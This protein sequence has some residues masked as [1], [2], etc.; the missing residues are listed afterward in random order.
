MRRY[1]TLVFMLFLV[2]PA[3]ISFSGCTRNPAGNYCNGLGYGLKDTDVYRI[4]LEPKTTGLSLAFGQEQQISAPQAF[5]CKGSNANAST[6]NYSTTDN[7]LVD[8]SPTGRICAGTWNRNSGGGIPDFTICNPPN[9]APSTNGLPYTSAYVSAS[10]NGVTS[11]PVQVFVHATVSSVSLALAGNAQCY[12]QGTSTQLD[13]EAC[14][15]QNGKQ[16]EFC[17]PASVSPANYSCA[18][19]AGVTS[20]PACSSSIGTLAYSV[21]T[22]A[23]ATLNAATN[24]ITAAQPGTTAISASIAGSGSSAGYFTTCP[25]KSISVT[26]NG[27]TSATVT[28]GVTQNLVTTVVDTNGNTISG[29]TLDYQ[30][31]NPLDIS[32]GTAGSVLASFPGAASVYAIC[33]PSVCNPA[34]IN[35]VGLFGTG[36]PISSNAVNITTPGT[37]STYVWFGAPGQSQYFVPYDLVGNSLGS[38][39]R[40]PYVPNSMVMDQAGTTIYFGSSHALMSYTTSSNVAANPPDVSVPG[41]VLAVSPDNK[42]VLINDQTRQVFYLYNTSGSV[43]ATFA[44]VGSAAQWTP[45]AKTLYITDSASQGTGHSN[46]LYVYNANTGW[47]TYDLSS[48]GGGKNLTLAIPSVGAY[49]S[50]NPTVAHTWC[51][52]GTA[53]NY[54]SIVFYPQGDSV[55]TQTDVLATTTDGQHVLGA[56]LVGGGVQLSDIGVSIPFTTGSGTTTGG[57]SGAV[58]LPDPCPQTGSQL[59]PLVLQHTLNQIGVNGINATALNAIVTSP[60]QNLAFLTY[61]GTTPGGTLPYYVPGAKGTTGTLNYITLT[62][63]N[64]VLAPVAGTFSLDNQYFFVSTAGDDLIHFVKTSTL[65]DTQQINPGLPACKPGSDP[66]CVFNSPTTTPPASGTVPA[67]VILVKPR[68]T[69]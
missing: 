12:S 35:Q 57:S 37:A 2:I 46:T 52:S 38:T 42:Q 45:D 27:N 66:S 44:G 31:T 32:V 25:P 50:G 47:T 4:D 51:P 29:L 13:S 20:V 48:S 68:N 15:S 65:T 56:A 39:V 30:S 6:Y 40:L 22:G 17:A 59:N 54:K 36:V 14:F 61:N 11:N 69:V 60:A 62:G 28:K 34:P 23:V 16:Y 19:P 18:L 53:S 67:T 3:G 1:L 41:V 43:A 64:A 10:A 8:V 21:S 5:T 33:Q 26:L 63:G 9:P 58:N 55:P 24:L 49:M 7:K